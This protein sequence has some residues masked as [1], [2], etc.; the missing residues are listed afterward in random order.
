MSVPNCRL[1]SVPRKEGDEEVL[2]CV[3]QTSS[4]TQGPETFHV[5]RT[6]EIG[7]SLVL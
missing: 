2:F 5:R 4:E 6:V 7:R 3:L 1:P